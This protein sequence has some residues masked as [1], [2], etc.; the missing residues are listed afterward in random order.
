M[1][2][3]PAYP[4]TRAFATVRLS[5]AHDC[6]VF[7][8]A[9]IVLA[10]T[11]TATAI[12]ATYTPSSVKDIASANNVA[13]SSD[14]VATISIKNLVPS[15]NY[16][17]Y[18]FT[19]TLLGI[20]LS[21]TQALELH[22]PYSSDCCK[23][24]TL[25]LLTT[26]VVES[27]S[28]ASIGT[29]TVNYAPSAQIVVSLL[30]TRTDPDA[31][32]AA[33]AGFQPSSLPISIFTISSA[34]FKQ[35][36]ALSFAFV[37]GSAGSFLLE[38]H[39]SGP[40]ESEYAKD[41]KFLST[42]H[43]I[44]VLKSTDE[45]PTPALSSAAFS[46]DGTSAIVGFNSRTNRGGYVSIFPC[47]ALLAFDAMGCTTCQ[48]LDDSRILL[49]FSYGGGGGDCSSGLR[50]HHHRRR[51][52]EIRVKS[53]I[54]VA[55]DSSIRAYCTN[56]DVC[57]S[58]AAASPVIVVSV[59]PPEEPS[60]PAVSV[61]GPAVIGPCAS[62]LLDLSGSTG[63][64]G[65]DWVD[66][67]FAV[68]VSS[69]PGSARNATAYLTETYGGSGKFSPFISIPNTVLTAGTGY[70][71]TFT[72]TNFLG[73]FGQA[74]VAVSVLEEGSAVRPTV[75]IVGLSV[76]SVTRASAVRLNINAF[77]ETCGGE[78]S[79][80]NLEYSWA[81][82]NASGLTAFRSESRS[83]SVFALSAFKLQAGKQYQ[84]TVSVT[85]KGIAA[86]T[87]EASVLINVNPQNIVAAIRGGG[88]KDVF[89]GSAFTI[90]A[91]SSRDED[92]PDKQGAAAGLS[93]QW[94]CNQLLPS[95]ALTCPAFVLD[96]S[97]TSSDSG[98]GIEDF[99]GAVLSLSAKS[100]EVDVIGSVSRFTVTVS[101]ATRSATASVD[102][103]IS[104]VRKPIILVSA[105]ASSSGLKM[106]PTKALKL[107]G[108][109]DTTSTGEDCVALWSIDE[110]TVRLSA[111]ASTA[112]TSSVQGN[113]T[114]TVLYL[115]ISPNSL[116]GG[117]SFQIRLDCG[118]GW[119]TIDVVTNR[120]PTPGS[121]VVTPRIGNELQTQFAMVADK[122]T[123]SDGDLPMSFQF[124][125][126]DSGNGLG[127][128]IVDS[129][130]QTFVKS[131]LPS[132]SR[133]PDAHG[134][135]S[136]ALNMT[137]TV[138]DTLRAFDTAYTIISVREL[139]KE[140]QTAAMLE[141]LTAA[142]ETGAL[143]GTKKT[144]SVVSS[145][146]NTVN[147]SNAPDCA[148]LHRASCAIKI[149]TCGVCLTGYSGVFGASNAPCRV[150]ADP[151][152]TSSNNT[153]YKGLPCTS[154][155]DCAADPFYRCVSPAGGEEENGGGELSGRCVEKSQSCA[156]DCSGR[157]SCYF[158]RIQTGLQVATCT[159][160]DLSCEPV[161]NCT[162]TAYTGEACELSPAELKARQ[163]IR[164][165]LFVAISV[166]I[167]T[168][169]VTEEAVESWT[170]AM[171]SVTKSPFEIPN[172]EGANAYVFVDIILQFA[173]TLG[174]ESNSVRGV[175]V[176][177][178]QLALVAPTNFNPKNLN[179][180]AE[181][182]SVVFDD[183]SAPR[184]ATV[185]RNF[186]NLTARAMVPGQRSEVEIYRFFQ[187]STV[188]QQLSS[189]SSEATVGIDQTDGGG[190][191]VA[192]GD[193]TTFVRLVG[194][195]GTESEQGSG[196]AIAVTLIS[197]IPR[198]YGGL[199][200]NM[201]SNSLL[202][203]IASIDADINNAEPSSVVSLSSFFVTLAHV[204]PVNVSIYA[205]N[206]TN[207]TV[208]KT[209]CRGEGDT[210]FYQHL[211]PYSDIV[212]SRNC[213]G[214]K[215]GTFT[216]HCPLPQ[217][218]CAFVLT[219]A[220]NASL[221][222]T[223]Q[224]CDVANYTS[225]STTCEC[226]TAATVNDTAN[227]NN[228]DNDND[229][230]ASDGSGGG[231]GGG[232]GGGTF[233]QNGEAQIA[234]TTSMIGRDYMNT[235]KAADDFDSLKEIGGVLPIVYM[236]VGIWVGVFVVIFA[237]QAYNKH[238][239]EKKEAEQKRKEQL[240]L[241]LAVEPRQSQRRRAILP[242]NG[243]ANGDLGLTPE[244]I[245][246]SVH[247]YLD[248]V[249]PP[250]FRSDTF[251][252]GMQHELQTHHDYFSFSPTETRCMF[253]L[254]IWKVG[255]V[256]SM[257]VYIVCNLYLWS[258]EPDDSSC[259]L[260]VTEH[261]CTAR[262]LPL[263]V[264]TSYCVWSDP[265][266]DAST[267]GSCVYREDQNTEGVQ[268]NI[269]FLVV[270][271]T[272]FLILPLN[273]CFRVLAAHTP[274]TLAGE[275]EGE[276]GGLLQQAQRNVRRFSANAVH[277]AGRVGRRLSA[278]AAAAPAAVAAQEAAN[279]DFGGGNWWGVLPTFT[280]FR[281][282]IGAEAGGGVM[283]LSIP[284]RIF[285]L[286]A[287]ATVGRVVVAQ[288][289]ERQNGSRATGLQRSQSWRET[290]GAHS[291]RL[292]RSV[293]AMVA[294]SLRHFHEDTRQ[295]KKKL[296]RKH[297]LRDLEIDDYLAPGSNFL[298]L[299]GDVL[300]LCA[301]LEDED[302]DE[303][304]RDAD[305]AEGGVGAVGAVAAE[306]ADRTQRTQARQLL[307]RREFA[308]QWGISTSGDGPHQT[309]E[310]VPQ[311]MFETLSYLVSV[312]KMTKVATKR[313]IALPEKHQGV[314]LVQW[315][316]IDCLGHFTRE[317]RIFQN[318]YGLD[319]A[320]SFVV[321]LWQQVLAA[322]FIA[323]CD[324]YFIYFVMLKSHLMGS[325]WQT[326]FINICVINCCFEIFFCA[327]FECVC[328][329]VL[330]PYLIA[331][332]VKEIRATMEIH[333]KA[334]FSDGIARPVAQQQQ[335]QQQQHREPQTTRKGIN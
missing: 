329:H 181:Q 257:L 208:F 326:G 45:P 147:C 316:I 184:L 327:T 315:F 260:H 261:T 16:T 130:E 272:A 140:D 237:V 120:A 94:S 47:D 8:A 23:L 298:N 33:A 239:L 229:N 264:S 216:D 209:F 204:T 252:S 11:T 278:S 14:R 234:S 49:T 309:F 288:Q 129:T 109:V 190:G 267:E 224:F 110:P 29:I 319:Y 202:M 159:V 254:R 188:M 303:G 194:P 153:G 244:S 22:A 39:I 31:A 333:L 175:L 211:C 318:K 65:R 154:D 317:A 77:V 117:L 253:F 185:L 195:A 324:V 24:V 86:S 165:A 70:I 108:H 142:N 323:F 276:G 53:P 187:M 334:L 286:R 59:E 328:L 73:A 41:V 230:N 10:T 149:H 238:Q 106:N 26:S 125:Y 71:F 75:S 136:Y 78:Q 167:Q 335:Q 227:D 180:E 128:T 148:V 206:G 331:S 66:V 178:D 300:T 158:A 54:T 79:A 37:A 304:E 150:V 21:L 43:T 144:I 207:G 274:E 247:N 56:K 72:L 80:Q 126:V 6:R 143:Q 199:V 292:V 295:L 293:P 263:D 122:W 218:S 141:L 98:G 123:D 290:T 205:L 322:I 1:A 104:D 107:E 90:D 92:V 152:D 81:V 28:V 89:K 196:A 231:G 44:V 163:G 116:R 245:Q 160:S 225:M 321:F 255:T 294:A 137:L 197:I 176:V 118:A 266:K 38:A 283:I 268:I 275:M 60:Q 138:F 307:N 96:R 305:G 228:N 114:D 55:P 311:A 15:S 82:R 240:P 146:L 103:A 9:Y 214:K 58:W 226:T 332:N 157:G 297:S 312:D 279:N 121:L 256:L 173:N 25:N 277:T 186:A 57:E 2:R 151:S 46:S 36:A 258:V 262:K 281:A 112:V 282:R 113:K 20:E 179:F 310:I 193:P 285:Q 100:E 232:G 5:N 213:S 189:S 217:P 76:R 88:S 69:G 74:S 99:T 52:D 131:T 133:E 221:A 191:S 30:L 162:A 330:G 177:V 265:P 250:I 17:V 134:N 7:C 301:E 132:G 243:E 174:L 182:Q 270:V 18:C 249:M 235:F 308:A 27:T 273:K 287:L 87:S 215:K 105:P 64:A 222:P 248:I 115:S 164:G 259:T 119:A 269:I 320:D 84:V 156:D 91:S 68:V 95:F 97:S 85:Y 166:V 161:C 251:G 223:S 219:N 48:W 172:D 313:A 124:S 145:V 155:A 233:L 242:A 83:S 299:C 170:G 12:T 296:Q 201:H 127:L 183:Y 192:L 284:E 325:A 168:D 62:L 236:F 101:D 289:A 51:L 271:I 139:A 4:K 280:G 241:V 198:A 220:F 42:N 102:V 302:N 34:T 314:M 210:S 93:F 135:E 40:S 50:H 35:G 212:L 200:G 169:Q 13:L 32:A 203:S 246:H 306:N 291:V 111:V 3:D 171:V 61:S 19:Q 67:A 63:G